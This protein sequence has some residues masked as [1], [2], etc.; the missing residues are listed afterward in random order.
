MRRQIVE[1]LEE[2]RKILRSSRTTVREKTTA[3]YQ[4]GCGYKVQ[5]QLEQYASVFEEKGEL[6]M[7][8][9]YEQVYQLVMDLFDKMVE[10]LGE[11]KMTLAEYTEL[12]E[13]GFEELR[14]GSGKRQRRW[15]AVPDGA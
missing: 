8:K 12:L 3:L 2:T 15:H 11:E 7:Q 5:T 10:L 9:E 13:T 6:D 4:I 14:M 1:S